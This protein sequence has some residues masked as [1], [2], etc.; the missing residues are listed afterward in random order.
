MDAIIRVEPATAEIT[1]T[2]A[3][4][5]TSHTVVV[6]SQSIDLAPLVMRKSIS[7]G[8][9]SVTAIPNPNLLAKEGVLAVAQ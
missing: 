6:K 8:G 7:L 5:T 3:V 4:V 1:V 9:C 2:A